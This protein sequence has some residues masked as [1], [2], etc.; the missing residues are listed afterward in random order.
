MHRRKHK[1][2]VL[3]VLAVIAAVG[4]MTWQDMQAITNKNIARLKMVQYVAASEGPQAVPD[5]KMPLIIEAG[6]FATDS[7]TQ[8]AVFTPSAIP[9]QNVAQRE[10]NLIFKLDA[11]PQAL[12]TTTDTMLQ[13]VE[14]W[15]RHNNIMTEIIF[16]WQ[17]DN[18]PLDQLPVF[19]TMLI[20]SI[21]RDLWAGMV[22]QRKW[23][24]T[25]PGTALAMAQKTRTVRSYIFDIKEAAREG[26]SL[27]DTVAALNTLNVPF[28]LIVDKMPE[29]RGDI[30]D[31]AA[32]NELFSG[33][34]LRT[35]LP[36]Q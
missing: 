23:F 35:P 5:N 36:A 8:E 24:E 25:A 34:V 16:D 32:A 29:D 9:A 14:D 26:E 1:P 28:L 30:S 11:V 31:L 19:A 10:V 21:K 15:K 13:T 27:A 18:P 20:S 4:Y 17:V 7:E 33:F 12:G 22:L 6:S 3:I 2:Y